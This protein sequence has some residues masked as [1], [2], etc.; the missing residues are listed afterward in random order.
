MR[1]TLNITMSKGK[2][3]TD[4]LTPEDNIGHTAADGKGNDFAGTEVL[5]KHTYAT[6]QLP[7]RQGPALRETRPS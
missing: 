6:V 4:T 3:G 1:K 7:A 5:R 2:N